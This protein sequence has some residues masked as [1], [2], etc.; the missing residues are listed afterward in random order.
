[1]TADNFAANVAILAK[2]P[3]FREKVVMRL[4][5]EWH[6]QQ[7]ERQHYNGTAT[8]DYKKALHK[9]I[10]IEKYLGLD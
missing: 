6:E 9:Q 4:I 10:D 2:D 8:D 3:E 1:M 5:E 7:E